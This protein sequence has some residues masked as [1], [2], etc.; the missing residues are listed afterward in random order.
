MFCVKCGGKLDEGVRFCEA[1]GAAV[2]RAVPPAAPAVPDGRE[3]DRTQCGPTGGAAVV[4]REDPMPKGRPQ[5]T[6]EEFDRFYE[7]EILPALR[8]IERDRK[9]VRTR[10]AVVWL[11]TAGIVAGVIAVGCLMEG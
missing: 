5:R 9:V 10:I 7:R 2:A 1:C 8:E 6:V 3:D 11:V 4:S